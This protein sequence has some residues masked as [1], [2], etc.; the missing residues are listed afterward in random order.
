MLM[1]RTLL[2]L[3]AAARTFCLRGGIALLLVAVIATGGLVA[4]GAFAQ[5]PADVPPVT[6]QVTPPA[7]G[8]TETPASEPI[9]IAGIDLTQLDFERLLRFDGAYIIEL[10]EQVDL[11]QVS[12]EQVMTAFKASVKTLVILL[13]SIGG[14]II[15]ILGFIL[16]HLVRVAIYFM[17]SL[18]AQRHAVQNRRSLPLAGMSSA[19]T[20]RNF[21]AFA[22]ERA[23]RGNAYRDLL[24][25]I[26]RRFSHLREK[27]GEEKWQTVYGLY[28]T[29]P[30]FDQTRRH[31]EELVALRDYVRNDISHRIHARKARFGLLETNMDLMRHYAEGKGALKGMWLVRVAWFKRLRFHGFKLWLL[32]RFTTIGGDR[33]LTKRIKEFNLLEAECVRLYNVLVEEFSSFADTLKVRMGIALSMDLPQPVFVVSGEKL[34]SAQV[35][36]PFTPPQ[37]PAP[38]DAPPTEPSPT[39]T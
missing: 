32:P 36:D 18:M 37:D 38:Q 27:V 26:K 28:Q 12:Y 21:D 9:I 25:D 39:A 23:E 10:I 13:V 1:L 8:G 20:V 11:S 22:L 24:T 14:L 5:S 31:L 6:E 15:S 35:A 3:V 4:Q 34:V 30:R 16:F 17:I 7:G 29:S 2:R 33:K 19:P